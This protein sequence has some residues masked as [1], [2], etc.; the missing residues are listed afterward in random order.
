MP[1]QAM[2]GSTNSGSTSC[3]DPGIGVV[4]VMGGGA[5]VSTVALPEGLVGLP[6]G[7]VSGCW[8]PCNIHERPNPTT[9]AINTRNRLR[10]CVNIEA[11]CYSW[12]RVSCCPAGRR[13]AIAH[14]H[15]M[16][17]SAAAQRQRAGNRVTA[18]PA[19]RLY[20]CCVA[21]RV[22]PASSARLSEG[23]RRPRLARCGRR[24]GISSHFW[25]DP[26]APPMAA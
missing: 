15:R 11:P 25:H 8:H 7:S 22:C 26:V 18:Q 4:G 1:G 20:A 21:C 12:R 9:M 14:P 10:L 2:P 24:P 19:R 16:R 3:V 5:G 23:R 6:T 17:A 13:G